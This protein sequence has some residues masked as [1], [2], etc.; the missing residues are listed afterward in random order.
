MANKLTKGGAKVE[1]KGAGGKAAAKE[2]GPVIDMEAA[3][4]AETIVPGEDEGLLLILMMVDR[5][6]SCSSC[7][8][9]GIASQQSACCWFRTLE[10]I[11]QNAMYSGYHSDTMINNLFA[12]GP[13]G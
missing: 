7:E 4:M 8:S 3:R 6:R 2:V 5:Q 1:S 10:P 11:E 12:Y 9:C 13:D